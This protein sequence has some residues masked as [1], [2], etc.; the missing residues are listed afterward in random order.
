[1]K[2]LLALLLIFT[3]ISAFSA[4]RY[5]SF[6]KMWEGNV[7]ANQMGWNFTNW[8]PIG[9]MCTIRFNNGSSALGI[10]INQ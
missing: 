7:C 5:N 1:M 4:V 8:Q 9:S 3:S 10:I 6:T 2:K